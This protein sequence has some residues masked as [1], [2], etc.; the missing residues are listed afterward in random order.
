MKAVWRIAAFHDGTIWDQAYT[1]S[2][3]YLVG[4]SLLWVFCT[5]VGRRHWKLLSATSKCQLSFLRLSS[6]SQLDRLLI[7]TLWLYRKK[8]QLINSLFFVLV[9]IVVSVIMIIL[10]FS[11]W[12][13]SGSVLF[14]LL[15]LTVF[16]SRREC[17]KPAIHTYIHAYIHTVCG[18]KKYPLKLVAIF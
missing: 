17:G 10:A 13:G 14:L 12:I 5:D 1:L 7:P 4:V 15:L 16:G 9:G 2:V 3:E 18:K 6:V 11:S 8:N